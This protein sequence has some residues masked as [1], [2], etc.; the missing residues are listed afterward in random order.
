VPD[1]ASSGHDADASLPLPSLTNTLFV[2]LS[3][4]GPPAGKLPEV[5]Y[6]ELGT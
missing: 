5:D 6:F 1:G 4:E 3:V 2:F